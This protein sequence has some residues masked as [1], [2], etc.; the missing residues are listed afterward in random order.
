MKAFCIHAAMLL[1]LAADDAR[2][3]TSTATIAGVV[4]DVPG[5]AAAGAEVVVVNEQTGVGLVLYASADGR[6][7]AAFLPTGKYTVRARLGTSR[8]VPQSAT[9]QAGMSISIDVVLHPN[10]LAEVVNVRAP[11]RPKDDHHQITGWVERQQIDSLPLNGRNAL[12]TVKVEPGMTAPARASNGRAF[13]APL[14]A[15]LNTIPRVGAPRVALASDL[16]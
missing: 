5:I 3:Q 11:T 1:A 4:R 10:D 15:G 6:Y 8:S 7:T 13:A 14:G 16:P 2:A 12:E 9:V